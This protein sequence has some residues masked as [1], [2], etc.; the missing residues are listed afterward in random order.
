MYNKLKTLLFF[1]MVIRALIEGYL[2]FALCSLLNLYTVILKFMID[3]FIV[4]LFDLD[5]GL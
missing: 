1:N 2:D 5:N 4:K 3:Y